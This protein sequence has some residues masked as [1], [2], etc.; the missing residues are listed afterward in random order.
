MDRI[1]GMIFTLT[2]AVMMI[3]AIVNLQKKK[4]VADIGPIHVTATKRMIITGCLTWV[5]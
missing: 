5:V 2:G 4:D 1:L 3:I